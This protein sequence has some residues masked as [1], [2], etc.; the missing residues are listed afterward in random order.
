MEN[1]TIT[2]QQL[3]DLIDGKCSTTESRIIK[4]SIEAS[5]TLNT[6]Y[7]EL[8]YMHETMLK[9]NVVKTSKVFLENVMAGLESRKLIVEGL[10]DS[11]NRTGKWLLTVVI[12][13]M[14][15][16]IYF[17]SI[18]SVS[19]DFSQLLTKSLE[20]N[21]LKIDFSPVGKLFSDKIIIN[22]FLFVGM[23]ISLVLFDRVLLRPW[24]ARRR[25]ALYV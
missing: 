1:H 22:G 4:D 11:I 5:P 21:T 14:M 18:D 9:H 20:I 8:C 13:L 16:T 3:L 19:L 7:R 23:L 2:E 10:F 12:V 24:F 17:A 6:K 25:S 15:V